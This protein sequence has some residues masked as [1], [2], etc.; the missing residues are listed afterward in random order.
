MAATTGFGMFAMAARV[1]VRFAPNLAI[2]GYVRLAIS[3]MS[4]PP[5]KVFSPP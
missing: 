4:A 2:S 3:L 5:A 1:P